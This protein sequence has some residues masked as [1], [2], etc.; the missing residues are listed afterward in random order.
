MNSLRQRA[1][2]D[3]D[4]IRLGPSGDGMVQ[5]RDGAKSPEESHHRVDVVRMVAALEQAMPRGWKV[6]MGTVQRLS[7]LS[8]AHRNLQMVVETFE[9]LFF[10]ALEVGCEVNDGVLLGLGPEP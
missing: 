10:A 5:L 3:D 6:G 1:Q 8:V 7:G 9:I 2:L 4:L